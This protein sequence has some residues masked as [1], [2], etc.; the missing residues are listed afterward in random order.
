MTKLDAGTCVTLI[1]NKGYPHL[2]ILLTD[3][4]GSPKSTLIV[5]L[6]SHRAGCD[7]TVVLT[8]GHSFIKRRTVVNYAEAKIVSEEKLLY[9]I[10]DTSDQTNVHH[11]SPCS[12]ELLKRLREGLKK[13]PFTAPKVLQYAKGKF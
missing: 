1:S 11:E 5:N 7:E 3:P 10:K 12:A 9:K 13:S 4:S 8:D 6:T 2:Y